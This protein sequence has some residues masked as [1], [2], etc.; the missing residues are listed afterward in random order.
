MGCDHPAR[1]W[2][3]LL[4]SKG[5]GAPRWIRLVQ[6]DGLEKVAGMLRTGPGRSHLA[7]W[8]GKRPIPP[9]NRF[10]EEQLGL[11]GKT[12][13]RLLSISEAPYP[14]LLR[15]IPDPPPLIYIRGN[16]NLRS[17]AKV[18]VVGSR[19]ASRR[20]LVTARVLAS[21]LSWAGVTVVS[22]LA[23]G[24]D[25]AAHIGALEGGGST[26]AV[27]GCGLDIC[28]PPENSSLAEKIAESG[29]VLSE[30]P[31]GTQ[32]LRHNFPRRN[33][34][35]S[36]LS[37]GVVV[38]EAGITSGAMVTA[39]LAREQNRE[40]FAVPG[41]VESPLSKGPHALLKHGACLVET[42]DDI[43]A[44]L[45]DCGIEPA[46]SPP[47]IPEKSTTPM[48]EEESRIVSVLE[49]DPKHIDELVQICNISPTSILPVLL[50]LEMRGVIVSCGG[51][52]YALPPPVG[53][54][55]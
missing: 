52:T 3:E 34:I 27:L 30:L 17:N 33:R 22:G 1:L 9:D 47:R 41:P 54:G 7:R 51:G 19:S 24:V 12:G 48:S 8:L 26:W 35:L 28:Y 42:V 55:R 14:S 44:S 32:P 31:F 39:R 6:R 18:C 5:I 49:L 10:V 29:I 50:N 25:R 4:S 11:V 53:T 38:V 45:P 20:G 21:G 36:G 16:G 46:E 13:C 40:L 15:E 37:L 2:L 23:R 43:L